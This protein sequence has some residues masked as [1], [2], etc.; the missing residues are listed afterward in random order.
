MHNRG[1]LT[2]CCPRFPSARVLQC[3]DQQVKAVHSRTTGHEGCTVSWMVP[4]VMRNDGTV[5]AYL[6]PPCA[7]LL[8]LTGLTEARSPAR[9]EVV[10]FFEPLGEF[11]R[12]LRRIVKSDLQL[13]HLRCARA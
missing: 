10:R 4:C 12:N 7:A 1:V 3:V 8:S 9:Y 13:H 2:R 5:D 11:L 6:K